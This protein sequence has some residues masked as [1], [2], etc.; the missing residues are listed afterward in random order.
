LTNAKHRKSQFTCKDGLLDIVLELQEE[1]Q[2]AAGA[3]G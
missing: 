1:L 3:R 2:Q